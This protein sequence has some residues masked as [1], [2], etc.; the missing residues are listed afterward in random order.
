MKA[1]LSTQLKK[2]FTFFRMHDRLNE[3]IAIDMQDEIYY[4]QNVVKVIVT[5][6]VHDNF[7]SGNN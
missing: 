3:V 7:F 4:S 6:T 5:Y 1:I 2:Y